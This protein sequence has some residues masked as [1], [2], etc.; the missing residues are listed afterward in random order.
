MSVLRLYRKDIITKKSLPVY[1]R[2][3]MCFVYS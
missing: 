3:S 1:K 2:F